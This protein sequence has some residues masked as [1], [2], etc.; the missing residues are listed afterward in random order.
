MHLLV[1][2]EA[3]VLKLTVRFHEHELVVGDTTPEALV[4]LFLEREEVGEFLGIGRASSGRGAISDTQV[5]DLI[6][7][8][9][10]EVQRISAAGHVSGGCDS[11]AERN[12]G[13]S[14]LSAKE[15][16]HV[17][18]IAG[19]FEVAEEHLD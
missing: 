7:L 5:P 14:E 13:V 9:L 18:V 3:E 1:P 6:N 19:N 16:I 4:L 10:L 12:V 11:V 8:V 2:K 17:A 15:A